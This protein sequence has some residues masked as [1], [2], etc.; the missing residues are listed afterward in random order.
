MTDNRYRIPEAGGPH[1]LGRHVNHDP[2]SRAFAFTAPRNA[3]YAAVKHSRHIPVFDQGDLGSCTGNAAVG[4]VGTGGFFSSFDPRKGYPFTPDEAGA[5]A[6]YEAATALDPYPG[7]YPPDD[8]GSDGNS[9]VLALRNAGMISGFQH[10]LTLDD[11]MA[12]LQQGPVIFGL[13]WY[14][15]MFT[16]GADGV[17]RVSGALAGGHEIVLDEWDPAASRVGLTNSWASDWGLGGRAYIALADFKKLLTRDGDV[18]VFVP[19]T[20]P[21]PTPTPVDPGADATPAQVAAAVR[22]S[23]TDLGL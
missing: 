11:A 2:R 9:V 4:C 3:T 21:A 19:L 18:T 14:Q 6:C 17:L 10:A 16:P 5:V 15:N 7:T 13:D 12:A 20:A 1:R 23:L 8:T 22:K